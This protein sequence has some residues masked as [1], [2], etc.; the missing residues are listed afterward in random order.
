MS[1]PL[2]AIL[3][4]I[5]PKDAVPVAEAL[6]AA[7]IDRI[8]VPLNSPEP[9]TSIEAIAKA[10]GSEALIGAGTVLTPGE[11]AQ[12]RNAGGRLIVSPNMEPEVIQTTKRLG[13]L[14]F[15]GTFTATECLAALRHGA[16]GLKIFP[17][18]QMGPEGLKALRAILP[19]RTE[20]FAVGGVGAADFAAWRQAGATGF[21]IGTALYTPGLAPG[22][23]AT[24]ATALVQTWDTSQ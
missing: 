6:I 1:R 10:F 15:P 19:P 21:G 18:L 3:R 17:A 20:V 9:L 13:L 7:G 14:S 4:G 23:V 11:V 12:V 24:R 22:E 16:D 5:T 8:E 2:I